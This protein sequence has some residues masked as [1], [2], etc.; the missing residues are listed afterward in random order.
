MQ[1]D[2]NTFALWYYY[3]IIG[4]VL[5]RFWE[6]DTVEK[7]RLSGYI[8]REV[9]KEAKIQAVREDISLSALVE[10]SLQLYLGLGGGK[11]EE[12][13]GQ[14]KAGRDMRLAEGN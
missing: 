2:K 6:E 5:K 11:G 8:D 7:A 9:Y 1:R 4:N 10:K 14:L 12:R 3:A 13:D